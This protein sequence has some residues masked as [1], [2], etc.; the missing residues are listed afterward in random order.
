MNLHFQIMSY[1]LGRCLYGTQA[2]VKQQE[3]TKPNVVTE[4]PGPK[5]KQLLQE[6]EN[7]QVRYI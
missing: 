2:A 7:I 4:V 5:T 3:P 1:F 6:L